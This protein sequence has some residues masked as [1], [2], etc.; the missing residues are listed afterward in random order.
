[1]SRFWLDP[2]N[3]A[4][5]SGKKLAWVAR[6]FKFAEVDWASVV[7]FSTI[8]SSPILGIMTQGMYEVTFVL[9]GCRGPSGFI[10][11]SFT[12]LDSNVDYASWG[13]MLYSELVMT[14]E[15]W[16]E[17]CTCFQFELLGVAWYF[18]RSYVPFLELDLGHV[19]PQIHLNT[20]L[21]FNNE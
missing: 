16:H 3:R 9:H 2:I 7:S 15:S 13:S 14:K 17:W 21:L 4:Q 20:H 18:Q 10:T 6:I 1:M 8:W 12:P 11:R 19:V 5:S